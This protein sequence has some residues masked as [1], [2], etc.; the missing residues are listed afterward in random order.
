MH[1]FDKSDGSNNY[2]K[3]SSLL[4]K[5]NT[6]DAFRQRV[7]DKSLRELGTECSFFKIFRAC[8]FLD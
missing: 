1:R 4:S 3:I 6:R 5:S 7:Q 8:T 2:K